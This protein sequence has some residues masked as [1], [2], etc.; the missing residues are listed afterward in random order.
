LQAACGGA[1]EDAMKKRPVDVVGSGAGNA[2]ATEP[3]PANAPAAPQLSPLVPGTATQ[4]PRPQATPA[5]Q[6]GPRAAG[7]AS[8]GEFVQNIARGLIDANAAS[9]KGESAQTARNRQGVANVVSRL[10]NGE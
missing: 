5:P 9:L 6:A 1:K 10:L 4:P 2:D 3:R 7:D 8:Y